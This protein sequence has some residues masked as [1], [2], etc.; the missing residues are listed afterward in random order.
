M[1]TRL[2]TRLEISLMIFHTATTQARRNSIWPCILFSSCF[3]TT[4][5]YD[6]AVAFSLILQKSGLVALSAAVLGCACR[7]VSGVCAALSVSIRSSKPQSLPDWHWYHSRPF[8]RMI[9]H[10]CPV[11]WLSPRWRWCDNLF[12]LC[13]SVCVVPWVEAGVD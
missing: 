5:R 6:F 10:F 7:R 8:W 3:L 13:P 11:I 1:F 2:G 12:S 4:S 9:H